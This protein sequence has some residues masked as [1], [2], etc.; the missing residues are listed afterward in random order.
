MKNTEKQGLEVAN[1]HY[2]GTTEPFDNFRD[3]AMEEYNGI[4]W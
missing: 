2:N 4:L 3:A 1:W